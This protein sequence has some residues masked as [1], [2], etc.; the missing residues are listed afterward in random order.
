LGKMRE[1]RGRKFLWA[2]NLK[3]VNFAKRKV[4][5]CKSRWISSI[6]KVALTRIGLFGRSRSWLCGWIHGT[7]QWR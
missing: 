1:R 3:N 4:Q 6:L 7:Q 2:L 5:I